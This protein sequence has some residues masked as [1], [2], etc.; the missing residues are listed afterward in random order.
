MACSI[1]GCPTSADLCPSCASMVQVVKPAT[2]QV[3]AQEKSKRFILD[4][5][6]E[7]ERW[8]INR[9]EKRGYLTAM[10]AENY[11]ERRLEAYC[12]AKLAGASNEAAWQGVDAIRRRR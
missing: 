11:E 12:G 7:G 10:D 8:A 4:K 5:A 2:E 3:M 6:L 1:C 9:A